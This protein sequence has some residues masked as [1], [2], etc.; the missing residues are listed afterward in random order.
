[1]YEAIETH[2][3]NAWRVR[4][5]LDPAPDPKLDKD[6]IRHLYIPQSENI[7]VIRERVREHQAQTGSTVPVEVHYLTQKAHE[8][9]VHGLLYLPELYVTPGA[10]FDEMYGWDSYWIVRGLLRDGY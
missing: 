9:N 6:D 1:M 8:I 7:D 10:R 4:S 2:I 5:S 3:R